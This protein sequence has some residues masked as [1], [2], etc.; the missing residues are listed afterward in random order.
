MSAV[1]HDLPAD[2]PAAV[3]CRGA[4]CCIRCARRPRTALSACWCS[5]LT[6]ACRSTN[7]TGSSW[8]WR[9][10]TV[11][12]RVAGSCAWQRERQRLERLAE[13][14]RAK[15][16]FFSNVSHEFRTLGWTLSRAM[17]LLGDD[18]EIVE[19]IGTATD[20]TARHDVGQRLGESEE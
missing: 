17:P 18:G 7:V 11:S 20:V 4:R 12:A 14:D 1:I 8:R 10:E 6:R 19:W 15:T 9:G 5:A 2:L 16:E 13:L 3:V